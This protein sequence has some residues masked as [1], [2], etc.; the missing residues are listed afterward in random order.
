MGWLVGIKKAEFYIDYLPIGGKILSKAENI[1]NFANLREVVCQ[2][3]LEDTLV[4]SMTLQLF[5]A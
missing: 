3:H 1:H 5:Q 4:G 2:Q